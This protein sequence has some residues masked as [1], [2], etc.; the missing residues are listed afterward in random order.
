MMPRK[1]VPNYCVGSYCVQGRAEEEGGGG[2]KL[3]RQ[4]G[5]DEQ[6]GSYPTIASVLCV[7]GR[8]RKGDRRRGEGNCMLRS[9]RNGCTEGSCPKI[10]SVA[11]V[12]AG[13]S[14]GGERKQV[15]GGRVDEGEGG[16]RGGEGSYP[17]G[18]YATV[19]KERMYWEARAQ[20]SRPQPCFALGI[21]SINL[22]C[23][24]PSF[25]LTIIF[26]GYKKNLLKNKQKQN[27][28]IKQ[29]TNRRCGFYILFFL[30]LL[31]FP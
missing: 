16:R 1:L 7:Q 30:K 6:G 28:P 20:E 23:G 14:R 22:K 5:T 2:R 18:L 29:K 15:E 21:G 13:K 26:S 10:S 3:P 11:T 8:G 12:F 24:F 17:L 31:F 4:E 25:I 19:K 9:R 27:K